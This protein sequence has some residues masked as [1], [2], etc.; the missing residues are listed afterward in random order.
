[1]NWQQSQD[2][3]E[4]AVI[5]PRIVY[6]PFLS[7]D[8]GFDAAVEIKALDFEGNSL[9]GKSAKHIEGKFIYNQENQ[10]TS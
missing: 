7:L 9:S 8:L 6:L 5:Q 3:G 10:L 1:M 4:D 2:G